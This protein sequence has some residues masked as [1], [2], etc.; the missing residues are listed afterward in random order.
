[1]PSRPGGPPTLE[2]RGGVNHAND[3]Y[4]GYDGG[5]R[6][7]PTRIVRRIGWTDPPPGPWNSPI[8]PNPPSVG[9]DNVR[10][11]LVTING[12]LGECVPVVYGTTRCG[13]RLPFSQTD[14]TQRYLFIMYLLCEGPISAVDDIRIDGHTLAELGMTSGTDYNV[15]LGSKTQTVDPL[16]AS[17]NPKW[18]SGHPGTAY[19]AMRFDGTHP[20]AGKVDVQAFE[21]TVSGTM[22]RDARTDSTLVTRYFRSSPPL[23]LVD[24]LT[25]NRYGFG[26]LDS[27][28]SWTTSDSPKTWSDASDD[29]DAVVT[30]GP[31]APS[32]PTMSLALFG[33]RLNLGAYTWS[34]TFVT[35][36]VE[37]VE[38]ATVGATPTGYFQ[39]AYLTIAAGPGGTTARRIYRTTVGGSVR[40]LAFEVSDNTTLQVV[41]IMGDEQLSMNRAPG[42]VS[43]KRYDLGIWFGEQ[44]TIDQVLETFR[45]HFA[46]FL[47][48]DGKYHCY[49]DKARSASA[50]VFDS[51]NII[52]DVRIESTGTANRW[53][54]VVADFT[55]RD[56]GYKPDVASVED[57][58]LALPATEADREEKREARLKLVGSPTYDQ[59]MRLIKLH[60]NRARHSKTISFK[61]MAR[62][63]RLMP[64]IV[65]TI[66]HPTGPLVSVPIIVTDVSASDDGMAYAVRAEFYD[67]AIYSDTLQINPT[68]IAPPPLFDPA[69]APNDVPV[70]SLLDD[71]GNLGNI[72]WQSART[73]S[74]ALWGAGFWSQTN[75][76]GFVAANVNDGITSVKAFDSAAATE[77]ILTM[78]AGA[79]VTRQF[80]KVV[81][82]FLAAP[83]SNQQWL[84]E[85]SDNG[86]SWTAP[87]NTQIVAG[88]LLTTTYTL[89]WKDVTPHRYW[90]VRKGNATAE[91]GANYGDVQFVDYQPDAFVE[92]YDIY[93]GTGG[94]AQF[95]KSIPALPLPTVTNPLV[96]RELVV[97]L[98]LTYLTQSFSITV[99]AIRAGKASTGI[100]IARSVAATTSPPYSQA[101]NNITLSN[102]ANND[103]AASAS[104]SAFIIGGPSAAFS[105]SGLTLG[106]AGREI[107]L[108]NNTTQDMTLTHQGTGSTAA[109]RFIS[110][111]GLDIVLGSKAS[112]RVLYDTNN[113]RWI[114]L[115]ADDSLGGHTLRGLNTKA[116][117]TSGGTSWTVPAGVTTIFFTGCAAGGGGAGRDSAATKTGGAGGGGDCIFRKDIAVTPGTAYTV[118]VGAGGTGGVIDTNGGTGGASS[119]GGLFSLTGGGGGWVGWAGG[120][121]GG[122]LAQSGTAGA[123]ADYFTY[124][125]VSALF[126]VHIIAVSG[127]AGVRGQ[128]G[129]GSK[130]SQSYGGAGGDGYVILEW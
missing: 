22:V 71:A 94:S 100:N 89:E 126:P 109:N 27:S 117:T 110:L 9:P 15:Y 53:T 105:I 115:G 28:F 82:T 85:Y 41:D 80:G 128:G 104:Y 7:P 10:D 5:P 130:A 74:I 40:F 97:N 51:S 114:I 54:R 31:S 55:N 78:D 95:A 17:V 90:R 46:G 56:N 79:G 1:M 119:F 42:S 21:A 63:A 8:Q 39:A 98:G 84:A 92:R 59:T 120:A 61:V 87:V 62:G 29:C 48:Y 123:T 112:F 103:V 18:V 14:S 33:G 19:I 70:P 11:R 86:S 49:V 60:F 12:G 50:V 65:A 121:A 68:P 23:C 66:S 36:G 91:S 96:C 58:A 16:L 20:L 111:T 52:G 81:I 125:G 77:G 57:P 32:A 101:A 102:G 30:T 13:A 72:Y 129:N 34:Y 93:N 25:Q 35:N 113:S 75:L 108:F 64:G 88:A 37:S 43:I 106:A 67:A 127:L 99:K 76:G 6:R 73:H 3:V 124:G 2:P 107:V 83:S 38:S 116:F 122:T 4:S 24:A 69:V 45:A 44:M 26:W 47:N 118:T